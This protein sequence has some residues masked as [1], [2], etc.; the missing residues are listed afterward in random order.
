MLGRRFLPVA[1]EPGFLGLFAMSIF[2]SV[3]LI[4]MPD[5]SGWAAGPDDSQSVPRVGV[6]QA[7]P[8]AMKGDDGEWEGIAVE[9]WRH[10]ARDLGLQFEFQE[11]PIAD[12]V[13]ATEQGKLIAVVTAIATADRERVMDL[14]H[15]YYNSGL[16]IAV[17]MGSSGSNW[18]GL[19]GDLVSWA[20]LRMA[21]LMLALLLLAA[22]LVWLFERRANPEHFHA[23]PLQGIADG[24]WWAA[25]TLTTVGYGDKA[26]RTRSG[27]VVA[28]IWMFAAVVLIAL[29]TAQVT[30]TLTVTSLSGRVRGPADLPHVRVG[31]IQGSLAQAQ[32]RAKL[33]VIA[34]GY[35]GFTEGLEAIER[36]DIDAFVSVEPVLRYEIANRFSARL[37][38]IGAPFLRGD[39]VFALP[40]NSQI[41]KAIN[42]SILAFM[43]T[44]EWQELLR[45]YL[46][47]DK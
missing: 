26:P 40:P 2:L 32:L 1:R 39:Y 8:F 43:D 14:S 30:S 37:Q 27:R 6:V 9:L 10:V 46:G 42:Q 11:M 41:R 47:N 31:T 17:P 20:L 5:G 21:G 22:T 19:L 45:K 7:P 13:A 3:L 38:L 18:S 28:V 36:G 25:V 12:M 24:L 35:A 33:G 44:D 34:A 16:A 23:R 29:F 15:P 4:S